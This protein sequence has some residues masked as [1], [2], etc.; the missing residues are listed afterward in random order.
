M[1]TNGE[2]Y[3]TEDNAIIT[4]S[5]LFLSLYNYYFSNLIIPIESLIPMS[6]F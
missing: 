3:L 4:Q 2:A 5:F 6:Y 1:G